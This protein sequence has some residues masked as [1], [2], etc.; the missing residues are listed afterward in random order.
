MVGHSAECSTKEVESTSTSMI[1]NRYFQTC[2]FFEGNI[3]KFYGNFSF[4]GS[5]VTHGMHEDQRVYQ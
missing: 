4:A 1:K 5:G 2:G 3:E